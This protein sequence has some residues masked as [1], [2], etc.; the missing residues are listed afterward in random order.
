MPTLYRCAARRG[1]CRSSKTSPCRRRSCRSSCSGRSKRC[2]RQQITASIF[3]H[4]AHG[5]LHI[6]PFIDLADADDVPKLRELAEELYGHVWEVGG[7]ISGEHAEGY[8]RTPYVARQHGPLMAAFR[9]VKRAVRSAGH[10]QSRQEDPV[11]RRRRRR[12]RCGASTY[13]LLERLDVD[14]EPPPPP[15]RRPLAPTQLIQLQLDWRPDEM[16][17]AA[18]MC[19]GCGACRTQSA[20]TRMCPTFRPSPREEASPRAKANLVR[21]VLTG[22]L[23]AGAVL[24]DAFKE[25]CDLCVHCHMCRLECPANVDIPK[26]MAEAKAAYVADQRAAACTT[27][28]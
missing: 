20:E 11:G 2:K 10:S 1:R 28:S 18:R 24:D 23:P 5:Q 3:G 4:A 26:L 8:S 6:R 19:N 9:E 15:R 25:I 27:G 16:T 14:G 22:A 13:P 21:G 17:Y 12:R 7:T